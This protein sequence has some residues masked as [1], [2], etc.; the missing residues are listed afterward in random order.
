MAYNYR[1]YDEERVFRTART[2]AMDLYNDPEK[3]RKV[4]AEFESM[5]MEH[6]EFFDR[7]DQLTIGDM[8]PDELKKMFDYIKDHILKN[9]MAN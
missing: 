1:G 6:P 8:T 4:N 3:L 7:V 5:K 2:V 9:R